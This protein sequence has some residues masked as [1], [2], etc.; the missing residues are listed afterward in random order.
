MNTV[1][2][3]SEINRGNIKLGRGNIISSIDIAR[4]PGDYPIYSSS[5]KGTGEFGR[6]GDYMFDEEL[7][8]WSVDG[9]GRFFFRP[10]HKF[11]VTNVSGF[12]RIDADIWDRKFVYYSLDFQH[13]KIT[14]D[15]QTKA[16]P[17][18]IRTLYQLAE[19][20]KPE[21]SKIAEVLSKVDQAI[22]QTESLIAKQQ[23]IKTGLM[24]DL[25]TRG[26]DEHGNLRS[27]ETHEFKD[28]PL[29]RIPVEWEVNVFGDVGEW[30]SGGTPSKTNSRFWDGNVPWVCPK[31]MKQLDLFASIDTI[32]DYAV[33]TGTK[34][35]PVATVFIVVRGMILAHTFPVGYAKCKMAFNQDVKAIVTKEGVIG[36][37][38][39]FWL[40]SNSH[41]FLKLTTTATH[42][43]KRFDM[44]ELFALPIGVPQPH[45]Q[46]SIVSIFDSQQSI[47]ERSIAH[48][49]KLQEIKTALMQD[50]LTGKKRVTPLLEKTEVHS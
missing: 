24:Q 30:Y 16:H 39:A 21:Q 2:L 5:A 7:I 31:D 28:S 40:V 35:M 45:E 46:Q 26:I 34:L 49:H 14:F 50:L 25:L 17:S 15:Y 11:S 22:E 48:A 18:V 36:R 12:M 41:Q 20:S 1:T 9:G 3:D 6:Y 44:D 10:K 33:K 23:R 4:N 27:E 47:I 19:F 32:T 8:T 42:G 29:G 37:Y 43:T 38:L 13:Q